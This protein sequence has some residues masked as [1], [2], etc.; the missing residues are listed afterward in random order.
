MATIASNT[1]LCGPLSMPNVIPGANMTEDWCAT[2]V[3]S[4]AT[5]PMMQE[6]CGY[7]QEIYN[8][9]GCAWC[10]VAWPDARNNTDFTLS[11]TKC[12]AIKADDRNVTR[13]GVSRCNTPIFDSAAATKNASAW[14]IGVLAVLLGAASWSL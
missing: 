12:M 7:W 1:T 5:I 3:I 9:D 8:H 2:P 13:P 6:C 11:F 14:K 4:N 10:N